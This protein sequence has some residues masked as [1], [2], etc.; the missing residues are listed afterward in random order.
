MRRSVI[1]DCN[2]K[3][4]VQ[5]LSTVTLL[6]LSV[7]SFVLS[8]ITMT[9]I[10]P[11]RWPGELTGTLPRQHSLIR[12][13]NV[14]CIMIRADKA[15]WTMGPWSLLTMCNGPCWQC[16]LCNGLCWISAMVCADNVQ[17]SMQTMRTYSIILLIFN[18]I[19]TMPIVKN[20]FHIISIIQFHNI[21]THRLNVYCRKYIIASWKL[22]SSLLS[23]QSLKFYY[24]VPIIKCLT[25][26][27]SFWLNNV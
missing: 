25:D 15:P 22:R 18:C 8:I 24:Y 12:T 13:V 2:Q 4:V 27:Y 14:C 17:W 7:R 26:P 6:L 21:Q 11:L 1:R 3:I 5:F 19:K 10:A 16:A 9:A 20:S 23:T